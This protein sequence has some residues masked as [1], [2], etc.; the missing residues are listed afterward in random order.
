MKSLANSSF[1]IPITII[2][3]LFIFHSGLIFLG[4]AN[5][6]QR[7]FD[8]LK[9]CIGVIFFLTYTQVIVPILACKFRL[10]IKF[11]ATQ[12]I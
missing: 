9:F 11:L 8:H 12:V 6:G 3:I 2:S 1:K 5:E 4:A 7:M 10:N